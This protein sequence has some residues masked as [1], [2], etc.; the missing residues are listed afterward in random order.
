VTNEVWEKINGFGRHT[1]IIDPNGKTLC[2]R[3]VSYRLKFV[4]KNPTRKCMKCIT[5]STLFDK[6]S[7]LQEQDVI[8]ETH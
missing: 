4:Q 8:I 1:H 6:I 2:G 3:D 7:E 5:I